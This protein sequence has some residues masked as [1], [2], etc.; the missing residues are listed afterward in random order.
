MHHVNITSRADFQNRNITYTCGGACVYIK[1][2]YTQTLKCE[3]THSVK[4][5][6]LLCCHALA[7]PAEYVLTF[8][9]LSA[10]NVL[11]GS[12]KWR[13]SVQGNPPQHHASNKHIM[14]FWPLTL[15]KSHFPYT[16]YTKNI[17]ALIALQ[18]QI[19]NKQKMREYYFGNTARTERSF[20]F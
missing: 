2:T 12:I 20:L 10:H 18:H 3:Y 9:L 13:D 19:Q 17:W 15:G 8:K 4:P 14:I 16:A 6:L 11:E 5:F 7:L 1:G